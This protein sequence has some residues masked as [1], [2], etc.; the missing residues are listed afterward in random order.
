[1]F[2]V[3]KSG[4]AYRAVVD[5]RMLNKRISIESVPLPYVHSEFHWFAKAKYF[6]TLALNQAYHQIP[7]AKASK[8]L[9]V[10][11]LT[12]IY[13]STPVCLLSWQLARKCCHGYLIVCFRISSLSS[14][15]IIWTM[16]SFI[17][18]ASKKHIRMV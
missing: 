8:P 9:T 14:Y 10:F 7:L 15:I 12:V 18:K 3:P 17:L 5:F 1:M 2:F 13:T 16:W 6:T 11:V 4:D